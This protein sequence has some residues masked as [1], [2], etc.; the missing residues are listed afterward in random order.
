MH[1][2]ELRMRTHRRIAYNPVR[3]IDREQT[4]ETLAVLAITHSLAAT[5]NSLHSLIPSGSGL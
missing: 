2:P 4:S 5:V 3:G 1:K